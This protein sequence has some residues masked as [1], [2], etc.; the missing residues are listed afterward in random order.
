PIPP[1]F[2]NDDEQA[3]VERV[4]Q[5]RGDE[6]LLELDLALLHSPPVADGWNSFLGAIRTGTT[7][8][9]SIRETIICR[10]AV[11]NKAWY[12]WEQHMPLL[13]A[14][15]GITESHISYI[16][17]S[18]AEEDTV[19]MIDEE[20]DEKY[21]AV[22]LYTDCMTVN[23]KVEDAVFERL[24]KSFSKRE[25]VEISSTVAAYN[26]VS[27]FLVALDVGVKNR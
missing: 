21:R 14:C 13:R 1:E 23:V 11:L 6:G 24:K 10:V 8:P 17:N 4:K 20:L 5:R 27:R 16:F 12:E 9:A 18:P 22:M 26:C 3:V 15:S 25:I 19:F 7:L 2:E